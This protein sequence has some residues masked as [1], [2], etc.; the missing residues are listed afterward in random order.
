MNFEFSTASAHTMNLILKVIIIKSGNEI[1][2]AQ[3]KH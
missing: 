1:F 2:C 3:S